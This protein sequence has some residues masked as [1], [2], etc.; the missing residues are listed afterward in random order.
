M[1]IG[2]CIFKKEDPSVSC[3]YRSVSLLLSCVSKIMERI[4]LRHVYKYFHCNNLFYKYQAGFLPGHP[5]VYIVKNIDEGKSCCM[6][7]CDLLKAFGVWIEGLLF[8]LQ[9]YSGLTITYIID[10]R[11]FCIRICFEQFK[12]QCWI[13]RNQTTIVFHSCKMMLLKYVVFLLVI[14]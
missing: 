10:N 5:T 4:I 1:E 8:K 6:V 12:N 13:V 2:T 11:K 14:C 3:N 9:T 7:F